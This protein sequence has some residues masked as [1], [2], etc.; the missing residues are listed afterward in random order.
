MQ[1][2]SDLVAIFNSSIQTYRERLST[3]SKACDLRTIDSI[4]LGKI[5]DLRISNPQREDRLIENKKIKS[6]I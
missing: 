2:V 3:S 4:F 5:D 6:E 1:F